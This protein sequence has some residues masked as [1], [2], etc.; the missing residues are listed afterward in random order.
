[1]T[2]D[3]GAEGIQFSPKRER[4]R[5]VELVRKGPVLGEGYHGTEA[6]SGVLGAR[7]VLVIATV[8]VVVLIVVFQLLVIIAVVV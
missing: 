2:R 4:E 5:R 7:V 1:M 6:R 8:L 3:Y